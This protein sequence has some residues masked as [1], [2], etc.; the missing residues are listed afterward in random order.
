MTER[1]IYRRSPPPAVDHAPPEEVTIAWC[2]A[3][4]AVAWIEAGQQH[5]GREMSCGGCDAS[6]LKR[7]RY[8]LV[9]STVG[10]LGAAPAPPDVGTEV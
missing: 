6:R 1:V 7:A 2:L 9:H 3:C 5:I 8:T 4:G 10:M